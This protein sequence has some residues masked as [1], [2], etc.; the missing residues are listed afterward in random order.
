MS[1][2]FTDDSIIIDFTPIAELEIKSNKKITYWYDLIDNFSIHNRF[3]EK[4]KKAVR[5]K[6]AYVDEYADIITAV[7]D[8]AIKN[9]QNPNKHV[10]PN[11]VYLENQ[12]DEC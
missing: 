2:L 10:M 12:N 9:F 4:E 7:S 1:S 3:S 8:K 5:E 11:G 6:Y